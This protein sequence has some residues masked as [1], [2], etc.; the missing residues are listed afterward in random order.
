LWSKSEI[1]SGS[2]DWGDDEFLCDNTHQFLKDIRWLGWTSN[3]YYVSQL[4][5][6]PS[7]W[8]RLDPLFP[9][10]TEV[11]P[12]LARLILLPRNDVWKHIEHVYQD[13]DLDSM[14]Q[15]GVQVRTLH[16][17]NS[18]AFDP[19]IHKQIVDCLLMHKVVL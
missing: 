12:Q 2:Q 9:A 10:K 6:I 14:V 1:Y 18:E 17:K 5:M 13:Y 15:V 7:L 11:F 4:F 19:D 16:R 3:Q 8:E